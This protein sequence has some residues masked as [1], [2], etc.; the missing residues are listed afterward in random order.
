[1]TRLTSI[2]IN[3]TMGQ[4]ERIDRALSERTGL[5]LRGVALW[6]IGIEPEAADTPASDAVLAVVPISSGEGVI[7]GF[8]EA[9]CAIAAHVGVKGHVTASADVSGIAEAYLSGADLLVMADDDRFVAVNTRSGLLVDNDRATGDGFAA[10]LGLMAGQ[11]G[12]EPFG[13]IGCGPVG[14]WAAVRL[15]HMGFE[16]ILCDI[17]TKR[18]ERAAARVRDATGREVLRLRDVA[19]VLARC[20]GVV[21]ATPA[22]GIIRAYDLRHDTVI[23]A[24]GV[25]S[26]ATPEAVSRLGR[27]FYHDNLPLGVAT[28]ILAA[29]HGRITEEAGASE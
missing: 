15:A 7:S 27:R 17:D 3:K 2:H 16:P 10:L 11:R 6:A 5:S 25:P 28:M 21:D 19:A 9:V 8:S 23:V 1:M 13:V 29:A 20:R 26:G 22:G 14:T 24:P 4:L 18:F 12:G